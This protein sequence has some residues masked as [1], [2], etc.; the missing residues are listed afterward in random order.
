MKD[1]LGLAYVCEQTNTDLM[2]EVEMEMGG[3]I[4]VQQAALPSVLK[5]NTVYTL[6]VRKDAL[7][8]D[9]KLEVSAWE[10][11]GETGLH[12][13][14]DSHITVNKG[15]SVLPEGITISE[16]GDVVSLPSR[17][18]E[19][20]LALNCDDELEFVSSQSSDITVEKLPSVTPGDGVNRFLFR[21][22]LLP[23]GYQA[24]N[25]KV[26]FHRK[27]L[28]ESYEEDCLKLVL[29]ENPI[30]SE[31]F[32]FD[33]QNYTHDFDRYIDNEMGR[34]I[35]PE[36]LE[37][38]AEFD[39][40]DPWVKIEKVADETNTYRV[41][42]GWKPNDPKAD[43]RK[44]AARLV[45][46]RTSD[47]QE[48]EAY[49]VER[50]NYGLPV[51][52]LNGTWWCRYNAIGD[53]RNFDDQ[54]LSSNDPASLAGQTV[55]EYLKTCSS[56]EYVRLWNAA[57][58][59]NNGMALQ[60]VYRD[61]KVTL[62]GWRSGESNH[63]NKAE[64][65]SLSP[66]GY[67]MP[68]FDDYKNI[69]SNFTIPTNWAGF[70]PQNDVTNKQYRSEIILEKRSGVQLD[71]QDLGE[72]WSFSVRSIAGHGDEPLTFYGVG[73]QWSNDGVNRNW[74]LLACYNPEVTGWLVRG[75]NASLEHN[76]AGANNTR[77]VRFKKSPVEYI[78]Q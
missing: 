53:S 71:G 74:L 50:R 75:N 5:R 19:F 63:I 11:G 42:G 12:P 65:T 77:N 8:A 78:Y 10:D 48:T 4:Y 62:D 43:G 34:F 2:V 44:Q 47:G 14:W 67:E 21:K 15:L 73:C 68:T 3:Q 30:H 39:N 36:G 58:E 51:T 29:E 76:G 13:D 1:T 25:V 45:V 28:N 20:T 37:L 70:Y 32:K 41:I 17:A 27:G 26:Y 61:G 49:I 72:L 35:M 31:G 46:R 7:S 18:M 66:D 56:E 55:Q 23:P 40:E 64:P 38:V 9:I 22:T 54:I 6:T 60:A 59:G 33:R 52:Y 57:Y 16:S 69:L 24:E